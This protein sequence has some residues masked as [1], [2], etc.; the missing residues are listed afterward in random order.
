MA[1][2]AA[3]VSLQTIE[4]WCPPASGRIASGPEGMKN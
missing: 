2:A 1:A 3:S 4:E